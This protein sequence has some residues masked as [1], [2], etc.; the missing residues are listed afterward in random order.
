MT[1]IIA[2]VTEVFTAVLGWIGDVV[3]LFV[4]TPLLL[5]FVALGLA[6]VAIGFARRLIGR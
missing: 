5:L 2:S 6:G 4:D 1:E 3:E